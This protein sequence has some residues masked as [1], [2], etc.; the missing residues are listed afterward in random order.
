MEVPRLSLIILGKTSE[1]QKKTAE[2]KVLSL[3]I[4]SSAS[5]RGLK[6]T[7]AALVPSP[8]HFEVEHLG[9]MTVVNLLARSVTEAEKIR[10][11][12]EQIF[13]KED[14][15]GQGGLQ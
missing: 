5:W 9:T 3:Q 15:A 10:S 1:F 6:L 12:V 8:D 11:A 13:D 2:P 4:Q 7:T 14:D